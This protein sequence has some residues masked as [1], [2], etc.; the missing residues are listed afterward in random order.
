MFKFLHFIFSLVYLL[1]HVVSFYYTGKWINHT[2]I[3]S[4]LDRLP[5]QVTT[6]PECSSLCYTVGSHWLSILC[7]V[8]EVY[9]CRSQPPS[10]S[11]PPSPSV[12]ID[13][14]SMAVSL[15]WIFRFT[16]IVDS[17]AVLRNTTER[18]SIP[19]TVSPNGDI[20]HNWST[21]RNHNQNTGSNIAKTQGISISTGM[22]LLFFNR[23][24]WASQVMLVVKDPPA[25][26]G[27][28]R[29]VCSTPG[30]ERFPGG[31]HGNLLQYSYLKNHMDRGAWRT[32]G[33]ERVKHE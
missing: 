2:Y 22:L 3:P 1:Y 23:H 20:L 29:D 14:F 10:C 13:L 32:I 30:L 25:S 21:K 16:L 4:L 7:T 8:S 19:F 33:S 9:M 5:L 17:H 26:A 6:G 15:N 31:G 27:S 18:P 12:S 11:N 24:T 28:I